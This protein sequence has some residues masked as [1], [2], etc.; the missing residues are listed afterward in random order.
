MVSSSGARSTPIRSTR[1]DGRSTAGRSSCSCRSKSACSL[2]RSAGFAALLVLCGLPRLNHPLFDCEA[3]ERATD[4]RYFLLLRAPPGSAS[5]PLQLA[6]LRTREP[7]RIEESLDE[8]RR[9]PL[10]ASCLAGCTDQSMTRQPHYGTNA[11]AP[12]FANGSAA[13]TPPAGT[14][15]Q[16]AEAER[17]PQPR[18]PPVDIA[19][20]ERGKERFGIFCAPC[21]GYEGD[22]DGAIVRRGFPHPPSY[23]DA[24]LM[25]G[26]GAALL[27]HDHQRLSASCIPMAR[28]FR[29]TTGG[30]SSPISGR[31]S[32]AARRAWP[33][34][35][36]RERRNERGGTPC[37]A[38]PRRAAF[39]LSRWRPRSC[40][41]AAR[42]LPPSRWRRGQGPRR[43]RAGSRPPA[44]QG[45]G[46]AS[47]AGQAWIP[48]R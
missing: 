1:A 8:A 13:Q 26:A 7:L 28:A 5:A 37:L 44:R 39:S 4:D 47:R 27:R 14:V 30:R 31:F 25:R 38:C 34:R 41:Q 3:V 43:L 2:R 36:T 6:A 22:G 45:K 18:P 20:L 46:C 40:S 12:V 35:P 16:E 23:Y 21:H 19:L 17:K 33:R 9:S 48:P 10:L 15:A 29:R 24:A 42:S 11:P 32:K